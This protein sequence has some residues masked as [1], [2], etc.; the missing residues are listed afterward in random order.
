M[1]KFRLHFGTR[2][3]SHSMFGCRMSVSILSMTVSIELC[4]RSKQS[5]FRRPPEQAKL[6]GVEVGLAK[7]PWRWPN[8]H[9]LVP[10]SE[11]KLFHGHWIECLTSN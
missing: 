7:G 5:G 9:G 6:E 11:K 1:M 2:T 10:R 4:L 8:G 3:Q